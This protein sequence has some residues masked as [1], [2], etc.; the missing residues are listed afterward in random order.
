MLNKRIFT[1]FAM[2]DRNL[3]DL[4]IGQRNNSGS[5]IEFT[6]MSVK[7]P[8]DT[9]WKTNCRTRVKGCDGMIVII[10]KN[11]K[12]ADGQLWEVKCAIEEGIPVLGIWGY[13]DDKSMVLP[14][15]LRNIVIKDWTWSNISTWIGRV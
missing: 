4:L 12:N 2:E 5:K 3:R 9:M 15:E 10:T 8:W 11:S 14:L 1:S 6:D 7:K 13:K